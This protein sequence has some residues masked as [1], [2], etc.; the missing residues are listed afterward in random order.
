MK[1]PHLLRVALPPDRFAELFAALAAT[2]LRGG[3]LDLA[4]EAPGP[5]PADLAAALRKPH[6]WS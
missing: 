5:V 6:P 4:A 2:G 1:A 3:W